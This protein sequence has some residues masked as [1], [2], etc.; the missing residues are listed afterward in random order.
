MAACR[1]VTLMMGPTTSA[2]TEID[3]PV[4]DGGGGFTTR[5]F[6]KA[7]FVAWQRAQVE[8]QRAE[9]HRHLDEIFDQALQHAEA[10]A[11]RV[12]GVIVGEKLN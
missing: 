2:C 4:A 6:T 7:T 10:S 8:A 3:H 5:R 11:E 12:F 1:E 9:A